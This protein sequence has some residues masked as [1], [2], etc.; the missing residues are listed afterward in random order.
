FGRLSSAVIPWNWTTCLGTMVSSI[1]WSLG[2]FLIFCWGKTC[3]L[4]GE[5]TVSPIS[6]YSY[7]RVHIRSPIQG[8]CADFHPDFPTLK[9]RRIHFAPSLRVRIGPIRVSCLQISICNR[10]PVD[11][12]NT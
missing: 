10:I 11:I 4:K 12:H 2:R 9:E 8:Q 3:S 5:F 6:S 7:F 1:S